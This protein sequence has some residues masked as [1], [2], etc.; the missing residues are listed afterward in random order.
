M[1]DL[2]R[3]PGVQRD[4]SSPA[5]ELQLQ[6]A[7]ERGLT[8]G[9]RLGAEDAERQL[10]QQ[11]EQAARAEA[12]NQLQ[13]AVMELRQQFAQQLQQLEQ[14]LQ[15]HHQQQE[16]QLAQAVFELVS[17]LSELTLEAELSLQPAHLQQ[18]INTLLPVLQVNEHISAIRLSPQDLVWWQ[19]LQQ[20]ALGTVTLQADAKLAA[21]S[22]VFVG[23]TQLHLADFRQ[24][25]Q[26][27]LPQVQQQLLGSHNDAT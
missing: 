3:F 21:G 9:K 12:D 7:F 1:A 11:A 24:R 23:A 17:K 26:N 18:A 25:L 13:N 10:K 5:I 16:Q 20:T 6:Q 8:E 4:V 14:Q 22:A 15:Q 19:Q 27:L 2:Y